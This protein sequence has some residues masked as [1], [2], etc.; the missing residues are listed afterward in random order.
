MKKEE[1]LIFVESAR[2][3][4]LSEASRRLG[5]TPALASKRLLALEDELQ[6]RLM[7][8]STRRLALTGEGEI[9]LPHAQTLIDA[10]ETARN[11]VAAGLSR[12]GGI[13]RITAPLTFGTKLLWPLMSE[14]MAQHPALELDLQLTD[15]VVDLHAQSIDAAVRIAPLADTALIARKLCDN[16]LLLC[17][18]P[19]YLDQFGSPTSPDMLSAHQCLVL[20]GAAH[21]SFG[22][23]R[24][25]KLVRIHGKI[26]SNCNDVIRMACT[27]GNGIALH[28]LWDV[29]LDLQSQ[30]LRT[31]DIGIA[32]TQLAVWLV[33]PNRIYLPSRVRAF[34]DYLRHDL[35]NRQPKTAEK[36]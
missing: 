1:L 27:S 18:A 23:G 20:G 2:A 32:P 19:S 24:Q 3:G 7:H 5:I 15:E 16:P 17:A 14:F 33:Y 8:R 25:K 28:S 31:I 26:R 21:W 13:L 29:D 34:H 30:R 11:S 9:F 12:V 6:V 22:Q 36:K 35:L 4:S 10:D